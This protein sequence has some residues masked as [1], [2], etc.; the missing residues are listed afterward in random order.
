MSPA[1][2]DY[3][4]GFSSELMLKDLGLSQQAAESAGLETKMGALAKELYQRFVDDGGHGVD[5]SGVL[6]WFSTNSSKS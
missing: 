3:K 1:D 6:P 2:N 4:P 5:F